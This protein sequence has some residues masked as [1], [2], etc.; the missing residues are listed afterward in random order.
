MTNYE[1]LMQIMPKEALAHLLVEKGT[2]DD[3]D[4]VY[5]GEDEHWESY[6]VEYFRFLGEYHVTEEVAYEDALEWLNKEVD[7][8]SLD[9]IAYLLSLPDTEEE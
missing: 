6:V 9:D 8:S 5:D 3:G 1:K 4:Y 7:E 2:Y